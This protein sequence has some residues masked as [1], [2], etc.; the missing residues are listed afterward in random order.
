MRTMVA[1]SRPVC[2]WMEATVACFSSL[3]TRSTLSARATASTGLNEGLEMLFT[4]SPE[5]G[6]RFGLYR[7]AC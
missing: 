2:L 7:P 5:S 3:T 4:L 6:V 1:L